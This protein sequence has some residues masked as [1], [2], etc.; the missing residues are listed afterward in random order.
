MRSEVVAPGPRARYTPRAMF[1]TFTVLVQV[2]LRNLV[3]SLLS[4]FVGA[5]IFFGTVLL[6]VGGSVFDTLDK[7]LSKSIVGS[8]T[9]HMQVYSASSKDD[10]QVY[11][12]FDGSDSVLAPITDFASL[13]KQLLAI[14]NV[15]RVV[16]MGT[17]GAVLGSGNTIDLTLEK[18]RAL[19]RDQQ[20][21]TSKLS[22]AEFSEQSQA[23]KDHV[24]QIVSVLLKD[25]ENIKVLQDKSAE[26]PEER[27]ALIKTSSEEFWQSF[28]ADPFGH[29]EFLENR[30]APIIA[31]ADLLFIRYLGTDLDEFQAT[32]DRMQIVDGTRVPEGK[33]GILLPKFFYEEFMKLKSA[34]RLDKIRDALDA[35]RKLSDTS[36]SEL[37]RF[38]KENLAQTREFVLQLDTLKTKQAVGK[39]QQHLGSK[40]QDFAALLQEFFA[41]TDEN[42]AARYAFFYAE[43]APLL[44]L[45]RVKIGDNLHLTSFGKSGGAESVSVKVYG[46]FNF[47]GLEKS[48]LSG[49]LGL[50]DMMSFR[51]LYGF[52]SHDKA[53]ELEAMK[54]EVGATQVTREGAEDALFGGG[55]AVVSE[56][57]STTIE[58]KTEGNGKRSTRRA[59]DERSFTREQIENGVVLHMAIQLHDASRL[60]SARTRADIEALLAKGTPPPD[61]DAAATLFAA[62]EQKTLPMDFAAALG[63]VVKAEQK[64]A[65]GAGA[66]Q[67]E[68]M[69]LAQSWKL[70]R[71][72]LPRE[73]DR[74]TEKLLVAARPPMWVVDWDAAAGVLGQFIGFFKLALVMIVAMVA[75]I[76]VIILMIGITIATL[77]RTQTIGTIRAI[78]GQREFVLWMVVVES[79]VLSLVFSVLGIAVGAAIVQWLGATGIPAFRDELYFFFSGPKLLPELSGTSIVT[80]VVMIVAATLV[81]VLV[82]AVIATRI[83]PLRA[84]QSSD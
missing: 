1:S 84:M 6:V 65:S 81:S 63:P 53:E 38:R 33:R 48:P 75:Q 26:D 49:A 46:T 58:E 30:L 24:R 79:M 20:D 69:L 43:L 17:S 66:S 57:T 34:R 35:G 37:Q 51:D 14:P 23:K 32:F 74:A 54:K 2:A 15:S 52:L 41:V 42:F 55:T 78:G 11:G 16:P 50:I 82:P 72:N 71:G 83:S 76:A 5:I 60:A 39:L 64:R 59:T 61:K 62:L 9:G 8:V 28:D 18:L 40:T 80:A 45:Y 19:Y 22:A 31:D 73:L 3:G 70:H 56:S 44:D 68:L 21:G 7:A 12:K 4:L 47:K 27:A 13:K 29:L 67:A 77:Q 36:D 25:S 10:L